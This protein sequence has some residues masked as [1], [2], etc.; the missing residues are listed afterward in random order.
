MNQIANDPSLP[1]STEKSYFGDVIVLGAYL[2]AALVMSFPLALRFRDSIAGVEGDVWSYLWA[3]GLARFALLDEGINPFR[4]DF[5][6]YPLGGATQLMWG[7]A[8]PSFASLPLQLAFGLVPAF[9]IL[10]LAAT[11][12][13]GYGTFLLS[14]YYLS[15]AQ[16]RNTDS[17]R[18]R[19]AILFASFIGGL[20]FAF[21]SLRLGYGLAFTNLFHTEFIPFYALFLIKTTRNPSILNALLTS[22]FFAF[23]VYIDF[24]IA[25]FLVLFTALWVLGWVVSI[26]YNRR[27]LLGARPVTS[28]QI[29]SVIAAWILAG[30]IAVAAALPMLVLV[31][32]DFSSEG[33]NYLRVYPLS[34]SRER[35]Y[36]VL[37]FVLPNAR[38]TLYQSL[39]GPSLTGVN[40]ALDIEG[41]SQLSPDR[42]SYVG[43]AVF[44]L[45]V[46]GI[47]VLRRAA[48][49][50]IVVTLAFA[51]LALGP[52]LH[53]AGID[54]GIPLPY[55]LLHDIPIANH[56]RIP[57]RYGIMAFLGLAVLGAAGAQVLLFRWNW[58]VAPLSLLILIEAAVL[59]YPTLMFNVPRIY[60][61][62]AKQPGDI[63]VL[64]I[65]SFNW[66]A[67]A[68]NE[69]YQA[70]HLKRILRAYTNRIAPDLADYFALRQ[71]PILDRSLRILE[72][73]EK[74]ILTPQDR[75]ED[76]A[77]AA[78]TIRFFNLRY[79]LLHV[80][81]LDTSRNSSI[82]RYL[83]DVL[84]ARVISTA[85]G[86]VA[87]EFPDAP[88]PLPRL[89]INLANN[90]SLRYLGRGWQT[91]PRADPDGEVGRYL[92]GTQSE[93]YFDLPAN[94]NTGLTI[95]A[96][97]ENA[98]NELRLT[99]NGQRLSTQRMSAGWE[100][101]RI[102]L[103]DIIPLKEM[104]LL[105]LEHAAPTDGNRIAISSIQLQ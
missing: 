64:E 36:D 55:A 20:I 74:G 18:R 41:D 13:T 54:T 6:F 89:E 69:V 82:D 91:E 21:C 34:Y 3:T 77:L 47:T 71:T 14:R 45:A 9:N 73:E 97:S 32:Q 59:P 33:G 90:D 56:I 28:S 43:I 100:D 48:L 24:Q 15:N 31:T 105:T 39:P 25:A 5:A 88:A 87:Y 98:N 22:L 68:A 7:T 40:S 66:R 65:P 57:M 1:E 35:S 95:R 103:P 81:W 86:V 76:R 94:I 49:F 19:T 83:R 4:N 44:V 27:R 11:V 60:G 79:A 104:N 72:G 30:I 23:N 96:F 37:S 85:D 12:L 51:L 102:P 92:T 17:E 50:W 99:L 8:L 78:A 61:E 10:Y 101:Y 29:Q 63:S 67:A 53:F 62:I 52:S 75:A 58:L 16:G 80:D 93:V 46:L 38:S 84:G 42:Q 26:L 70:F 2:A